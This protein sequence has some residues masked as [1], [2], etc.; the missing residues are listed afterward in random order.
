IQ[1]TGVTGYIGFQ[2]LVLALIRSHYVRAVVRSESNI[3]DL[4]RKSMII[5][6]S[7][8][9]GRLEFAVVPDFL[10]KDAIFNALDSI[11]V[12]IHLASPLA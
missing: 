5:T 12:I 6:E 9:Q 7:V 3:C 1:I 11:S 4:K 10:E 2:T 8:E